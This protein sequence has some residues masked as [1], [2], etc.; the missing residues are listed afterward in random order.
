MNNDYDYLTS[1]NI[2]RTVEVREN[3][4]TVRRTTIFGDGSRQSATTLW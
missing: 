3:T 4:F 2:G 1:D